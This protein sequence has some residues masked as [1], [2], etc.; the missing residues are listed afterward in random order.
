V[1]ARRFPTGDGGTAY[2]FSKLELEV[3]LPP[4]RCGEVGLGAVQ[5]SA[6]FRRAC[7]RVMQTAF[8]QRA[9][10]VCPIAVTSG[11]APNPHERG[12]TE[13]EAEDEG[14]RNEHPRLRP[15]HS[16]AS[17]QSRGTG[18][19]VESL[20]RPRRSDCSNAPHRLLFTNRYL[21]PAGIRRSA[22]SALTYSEVTYAA[23]SP[24]STRKVAPFTYDD[25]SL[26]RKSAA[27][28]ISLGFASRPIGRWIR[29]RA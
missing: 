9:R 28:T 26:A 3:P 11:R 13:D 17:S 18:I 29:R 14:G 5:L 12:G 27:F 20:G 7:I 24:P 2:S 6:Q 15:V 16:P 21:T 10:R 22:S 19:G 4:Q 8:G 23:V 1:V 25:S